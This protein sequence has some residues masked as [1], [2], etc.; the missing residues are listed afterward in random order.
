MWEINK[1]L[2]KI[3]QPFL[4]RIDI[5]IEVPRLKYKDLSKSSGEEE[6]AVIRQRVVMSRERQYLR[7]ENRLPNARYSSKEVQVHC[8]LDREGEELMEQAYHRMNLTAR[9]YH[10]ILK[11]ARTIADMEGS[12][13]IL[14]KHLREGIAYRTLDK[15]YWG[16]S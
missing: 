16:Y 1:Y 7:N 2:G 14:P 6:S 8:A 15:K 10:R 11:V 9:S 12:D 3:S 4:D 13:L 5:C